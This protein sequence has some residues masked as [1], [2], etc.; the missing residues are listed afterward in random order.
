MTLE[1]KFIVL[2]IML[3]LHIVDDYYLQG[4]LAKLKQKSW[5]KEYYPD[6]L[7]KNDYKIALIEHAFSWSFMV[8]LPMFVL[9]FTDLSRPFFIITAIC[10]VNNIIIHAYVDHQK[11]NKLNINL[12]VD[13]SIH[14][15][16]VILTWLQCFILFM[17]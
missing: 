14:I 12:I 10:F 8:M 9:Y 4:V 3:F 1:Q 7:Y 13:Q 17:K 2:F 16:Y 11:A 6:N 15:G 5:W